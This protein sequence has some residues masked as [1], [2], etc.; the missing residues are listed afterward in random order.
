VNLLPRQASSREAIPHDRDR[1]FEA[2]VSH[3]VID[4]VARTK[5]VPALPSMWLNTVLAAMTPSRPLSINCNSSA[6]SGTS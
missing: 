2:V 3:Q 1:A 4:G 5:I 6:S